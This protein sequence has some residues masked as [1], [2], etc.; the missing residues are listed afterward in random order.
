VAGETV[1]GG[2]SDRAAVSPEVVRGRAQDLERDQAQA[3]GR[4]ADSERPE[5]RAWTAERRRE[6]MATRVESVEPVGSGQ[7][8]PWEPSAAPRVV[9]DRPAG[10]RLSPRS[11]S[12]LLPE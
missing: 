5:Y 7:S 9:L 3:R 1:S 10:A 12:R 6:P 11:R 8:G 2:E 4:E